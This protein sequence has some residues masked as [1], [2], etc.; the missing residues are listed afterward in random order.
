MQTITIDVQDDV[1]DKVMTLLSLFPQE[2]LT[3][4]TEIKENLPI[5][6]KVNFSD[7]KITAFSQVEDPVA[8]QRQIR[9][10]WS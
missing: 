10:E 9:D 7:F 1:L 6:K 3:I 4:R 2:E 8:W 5:E